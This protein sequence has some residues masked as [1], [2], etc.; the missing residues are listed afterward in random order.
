MDDRRDKTID[1]VNEG[2]QA[3]YQ[4]A[5]AGLRMIREALRNAWPARHSTFWYRGA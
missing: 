5:W 2:W 4:N 1:E 3:N